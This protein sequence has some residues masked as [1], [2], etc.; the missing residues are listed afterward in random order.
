MRDKIRTILRELLAAE[1]DEVSTSAG[2]GAFETPKAFAAKGKAGKVVRNRIALKASGYTLVGK[3]DEGESSLSEN[4]YLAFKN[5]PS[6]S[7]ARKIGESVRDI[8]RALN[9]LDRLVTMSARLKTES[10]ME[11]SGLWKRTAK[12]LTMME[13]RLLRMSEKIRELKS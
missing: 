5:D 8:N 2:A 11:A 12:H 6:K 3:D 13:N 1:L 9:E 10:N 7:T 4:R